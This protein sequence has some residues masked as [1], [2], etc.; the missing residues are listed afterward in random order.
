MASI[1][2]LKISVS[3]Q[4]VHDEDFDL[5]LEVQNLREEIKEQ[6]NL[7][8]QLKEQLGQEDQW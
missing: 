4:T 6:A 5:M 3:T 8:R 1:E 2:H 7:I